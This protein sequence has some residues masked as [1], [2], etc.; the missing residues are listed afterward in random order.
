MKPEKA[1]VIVLAV[2]LLGCSHSRHL[3]K[4]ATMEKASIETSG[5]AE[6]HAT[7]KDSA[8]SLLTVKNVAAS[9]SKDMSIVETKTESSD[10][11]VLTGNFKID[12]AAGG[13]IELSS[14]DIK[15]TAKYDPTTGLIKAEVYA[16]GRGKQTTYTREITY[17]DKKD[18]NAKDSSSS[19]ANVLNKK[20]DSSE[21]FAAKMQASKVVKDKAVDS[22][23]KWP[24]F[25]VLGL[26]AAIVVIVWIVAKWVKIKA[27]IL[28]KISN[29]I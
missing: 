20:V 13:G 15:L 29:D 11:I 16:K 26:M 18:L 24:I 21:A 8:N 3:T 22:K 19:A 1:Q 28:K 10:P 7:I 25:Q 5:K 4:S 2:L 6:V 27:W 23:T 17:R 12:S 9:S 14:G